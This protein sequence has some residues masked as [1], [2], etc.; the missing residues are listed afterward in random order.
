METTSQENKDINISFINGNI[1][2]DILN[3]DNILLLHTST[4]IACRNYGI[5]SKLVEKCPYCDIAGLRCKDVDFKYY[6]R[7]QDRSEEGTA[8]IHSPPLYSKG[9]KIGTLISQYGTGE[10]YEKNKETQN[11]IRGCQETPFRRCEETPL[12]KRLREDT[13]KNRI[14]YFNKSLFYLAN[15]VSGKFAVN[16]FASGNYASRIFASGNFA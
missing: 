11:F 5:S 8:Y 10:P 3:Q 2:D 15:I 7:K 9:V 16:K 4:S 6:A 13:V 1:T 14:Y 12:I